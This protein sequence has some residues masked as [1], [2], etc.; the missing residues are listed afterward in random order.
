MAG[1]GEFR[2]VTSRTGIFEALC[3]DELFAVRAVLAC[4]GR[5]PGLAEA[6]RRPA[7]K[8]APVVLLSCTRCAGCVGVGA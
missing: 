3:G 4:K 5:E 1:P 2:L 8:V 7:P 6:H